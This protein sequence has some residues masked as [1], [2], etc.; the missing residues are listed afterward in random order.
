MNAGAP[1]GK[2]VPALLVAPVEIPIYER[3]LS[4]LYLAKDMHQVCSKIWI[5]SKITVGRYVFSDDS[6]TFTVPIN[7]YK[8]DRFIS[9]TF[10]CLSEVNTWI[11]RIIC[12]CSIFV[13]SCMKW[14]VIV[15]LVDIGG[16]V[17]HLCLNVLFKMNSLSL[18]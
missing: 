12:R 17:D 4:K 18:Y 1:N 2:A 14:E 16:I 11:S 8:N 9:A 3:E 7:I 10:M 6:D 15:R 5:S 13:F